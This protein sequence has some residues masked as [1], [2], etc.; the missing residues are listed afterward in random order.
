M[1]DG[2]EYNIL[3]MKETG[4]P[5]EP[6]YASE[7]SPLIIGPNGI[8]KD[9]PNPNAAKLFQSFCFSRGGPAAHHRCRRPALGASADPGEA[10]AYAV[11]G[12]QDHEGRCR[13]GGKAGRQHQVA[14]Y[15]DFPRLIPGVRGSFRHQ[16]HSDIGAIMTSELPKTAVAET[17][18]AKIAALEPGALPAATTRKCEDLLIDIVGLCVTARNED[19]V[20]S[21]MAGCD[22]DGSCTVIGH[23]R[24]LTAAGAAFVNGTAAHGEDFDDTFEGGPGSCRR[25]DRAGGAGGLRA[26]QSRWPHGADGHCGRHRSAVSVESRGAEGGP[27]GRLSSDRD[28]RRDGGGGRRRRGTRTQRQADRRCARHCRQ[29]GRRHH[30]ISRRRR[31]DQA[32]A[33]RLGGAVGASGRAAGEGGLCRPAHGVRRRAWAVSRFRPYRRRAITTH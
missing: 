20:R 6:V 21:A 19:Y 2:N 26:A 4:R 28:L 9:S 15:Q 10:R 24:T 7:G 31:L 5:V 13:G 33:C 3:Q 1:A 30:R 25:G 32:H 29:H 17:L 27:Q 11:Q 12:H 14:L 16:S 8:F 18:A 22:D 23:Q